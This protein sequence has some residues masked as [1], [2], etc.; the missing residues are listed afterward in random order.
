MSKAA[1]SVVLT[2]FLVVAFC[3]SANAQKV[4]AATAKIEIG[5]DNVVKISGRFADPKGRS[6]AKNLSFELS[7]AGFTDIAANITDLELFDS[8]GEKIA[9]K[10]LVPGE[11]LA[12]REI[13]EWRY[14][15]DISPSKER[16]TAAH[17]S[18]RNDSVAVLMT[19]DLLP[20]MTGAAEVT[21]KLPNRWTAAAD[22]TT[23]RKFTIRDTEK[24]IIVAGS[25]LRTQHIAAES[26][27]RILFATIGEWRFTDDEA[28]AAA[29]EIF[30]SYAGLF[31]VV[32]ERPVQ[33]FVIPF[34][35][36]TP[37]GEWQAETRGNTISIVS[38]DMAFSTQSVQRLHE[39]L[40]HELF[41][42]WLPNMVNFTGG[43]DWFYEGFALYRSLRLGLAVNRISFRD[44]LDTLSRAATIAGM[45]TD[46]EPLIAASNARNIGSDTNIYARGLIFAFLCD[47]AML[48]DSKGKRSVDD[49]LRE[50]F[51][52]GRGEANNGNETILKIMRNRPEL[53]SVAEKYAAGREPFDLTPAMN[54]IG[55]KDRGEGIRV[56]LAVGEEPNGRQKEILDRLGYNNW[57]KLSPKRR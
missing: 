8:A 21:L 11:Y 24:G 36:K 10:T 35:G 56:S 39:Q 25:D 54:A 18:W 20:Q 31:G 47:A 2:A 29:K 38:S 23:G 26:G 13:A 32:P 46:P 19:A 48:G 34:P 52:A 28:A 12:E 7:N 30:T 37:F 3:S 33:V 22:G 4:S 40:R 17:I 55:L 49:V 9:F 53:R 42:I 57:R 1:R 14:S 43:Y 45:Q 50:V 15:K 16:Y 6:R 41:H 5:P 51:D 27:G 44:Y